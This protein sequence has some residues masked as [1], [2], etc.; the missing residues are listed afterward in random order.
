MKKWFD[1]VVPFIS[2]FTKDRVILIMDN[3]G[4]HKLIDET[5]LIKITSLPANVTSK[6]QPMDMGILQ[7][8]KSKAC[9]VLE[10]QQYPDT[11]K[12][13]NVHINI[14]DTVHIGKMVWDQVS[15]AT[16]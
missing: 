4:A 6:K 16:I 7:N 15:R 2:G 12:L 13:S 10:V 5:G 8:W 11:Y 3:F 9:Q 1:L 14:L